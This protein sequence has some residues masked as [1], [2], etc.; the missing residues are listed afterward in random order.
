MNPHAADPANAATAQSA[1]PSAQALAERVR[2]AMFADDR[3][4]QAMGI[5]I[6]AI[7][8][9]MATASMTVREDMLNGFAICH[10]GFI[11]TLADSAF[12]F[13]CNSYNALTVA[14]GFSVDFVAPA[15]LGERLVATACEVSR[16]GR[17]GIY[18]VEVRNDRGERVAVF[19]GR[20]HRMKDRMVVEADPAAR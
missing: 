19:R 9:G 3:A 13:A 17:T 16:S 7:G 1:A 20:S 12:A 10:G 11:A 5:R 8:P 15:R 4:S 2:T 14:S 6:D 18:D